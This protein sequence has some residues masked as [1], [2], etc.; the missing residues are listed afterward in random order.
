MTTVRQ[1]QPFQSSLTATGFWLGLTFGRVV[2]GF[3]TPLFGE[4]ICVSIYLSL[5]ICFELIFWLVPNF[6]ASAVAVGFVGFFLAP[7]FPASVI[8]VTKLL[9]KQLHVSALGFATGLGGI[10]SGA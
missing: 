8:V 4:R 9:P 2:L 1:G 5:A 7:M 3:I 6:V 10:G